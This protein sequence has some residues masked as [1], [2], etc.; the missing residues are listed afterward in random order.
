MKY[1]K[2]YEDINKEPQVGDYVICDDYF[3]KLTEF[4]ANNIGQITSIDDDVDNG[5]PYNIKYNNIPYNIRTWFFYNDD[6]N[7]GIRPMSIEEIIFFSSNKEE[8]ERYLQAN[9]YN[10]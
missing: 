5:A 6:H 4:E 9:K 2:T 10:L 1:I 3:D 7:Y 8:V